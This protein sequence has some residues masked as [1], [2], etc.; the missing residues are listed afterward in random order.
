MLSWVLVT[1]GSAGCDVSAA[2]QAGQYREFAA[3]WLEQAGQLGTAASYQTSSN[4]N[5]WFVVCRS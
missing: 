1:V 3:T 2:P 4:E 5:P